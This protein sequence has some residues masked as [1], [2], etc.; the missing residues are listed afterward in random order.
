MRE[1]HF[2]HIGATTHE[3]GIYSFPKPFNPTYDWRGRGPYKIVN[4]SETI[5]SLDTFYPY[6]YHKMDT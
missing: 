6:G 1:T 2:P 3:S 5:V 4:G